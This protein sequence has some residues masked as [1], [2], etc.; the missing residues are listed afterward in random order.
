MEVILGSLDQVDWNALSHAYGPA[1]NVPDVLRAFAFGSDSER[2]KRLEEEWW[3]TI[4]HQG[5]YY[6]ATK[7]VVPFLIEIARPVDAGTA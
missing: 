6:S 5:T 7:A 3:G 2:T 1:T 4:I